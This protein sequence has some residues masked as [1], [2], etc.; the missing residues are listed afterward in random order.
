[1]KETDE[2][3][4]TW[5]QRI[6]IS[7]LLLVARMIVEGPDTSTEIDKLSTRI[8]FGGRSFKE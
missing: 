2:N 1:M 5:R 7:I 8:S 3:N 4:L 6:T